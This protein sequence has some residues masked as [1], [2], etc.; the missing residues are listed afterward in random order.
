MASAWQGGFKKCVGV[1]QRLHYTTHKT[2]GASSPIFGDTH[3]FIGTVMRREGGG[4]KFKEVLRTV[5]KCLPE[6]WEALRQLTGGLPQLLEPFR[7]PYGCPFHLKQASCFALVFSPDKN[8]I[9]SNRLE[10]M[11]E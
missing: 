9:Q 5:T 1:E 3:P 2:N 6:V 10:L 8:E 11:P 4:E 7:S